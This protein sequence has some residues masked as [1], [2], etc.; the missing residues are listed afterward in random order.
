MGGG[1]VTQSPTHTIQSKY[2]TAAKS[3]LTFTKKNFIKNH[4]RIM[5]N[6][7]SSLSYNSTSSSSSSSEAYVVDRVTKKK[8]TTSE[9]DPE[10]AAHC[11]HEARNTLHA[12]AALLQQQQQ[13]SGSSADTNGSVALAVSLITTAVTSLDS[14]IDTSKILRGTYTPKVRRVSVHRLIADT[15]DTMRPI[16]AVHGVV[17]CRLERR[18][19]GSLYASLDAALLASILR[20]ILVNTYKHSGADTLLV[21]IEHSET[22]VHVHMMDNGQGYPRPLVRSYGLQ[23]IE[24][25][26]DAMGG[27]VVFTNHNGV[28]GAYTRLQLPS[29]GATPRLSHR[30][31]VIGT[32]AG[33]AARAAGGATPEYSSPAQLTRAS[34]PVPGVSSPSASSGDESLTPTVTS[35]PS[36]IS[37][38]T[39]ASVALSEITDSSG[40]PLPVLRAPPTTPADGLSSPEPP[41]TPLP[42]LH[43]GVPAATSSAVAVA[44]VNVTSRKS[45]RMVLLIDD[46]KIL[47]RIAAVQLADVTHVIVSTAAD[48]AAAW[49]RYH[50]SITHVIVDFSLGGHTDGIGVL[51]GFRDVHLADFR[52]VKIIVCTGNSKSYVNDRAGDMEGKIVVKTKPMNLL[53]LIR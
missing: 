41:T 52:R 32:N 25:M 11:A 12:A 20:N 3:L 19:P 46:D 18:S 6:C 7:S 22:S 39:T 38:R 16:L 8:R 28:G 10:I 44:A 40:T 30:H 14:T 23:M 13:Q 9:M 17:N 48:A 27:K 37:H 29:V 33:A 31:L 50:A 15:L 2:P 21:R 24:R 53:E 47:C 36:D 4:T 45:S 49:E 43:L 42:M 5:G 34:S 35:P 1:E 51:R 26:V